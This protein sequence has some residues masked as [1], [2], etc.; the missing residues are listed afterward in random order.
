MNNLHLYHKMLHQLCQWF[1]NE[2]ITRKRNMALLLVGL[3]ASSRIHLS[4]IVRK[5]PLPSKDLSLVNRLRRFLSN[6]RWS[7]QEWYRPVAVQ[8]L[9]PFAGGRICLVIDCTKLG[10][11]YRLMI[12]GIAYRRRTLPLAWS[13]HRGRKGHTTANEQIALFLLAAKT[14]M[15]F[16]H[17][18][19][20]PHQ[21]ALVGPGL[22]E[23]EH[24]R[25]VPWRNPSHRLGPTYPEERCRLVLA[26]ASLAKGRR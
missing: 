26:A 24:Y 18:P 20:R 25:L 12:I 8:L 11:R 14:R 15:A 16:C 9:Q 19:A 10:F 3:Y 13:I 2:R 21:G 4:H 6:P 22:G 5:W 1:P 23:I 7:V 17:P